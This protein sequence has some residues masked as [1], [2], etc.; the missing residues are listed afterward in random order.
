VPPRFRL[1]CEIG[2]PIADISTAIETVRPDGARQLFAM[3]DQGDYLE[4]IEERSQQAG[5]GQTAEK[6]IRR[7]RQGRARNDT[8][9]QALTFDCTFVDPKHGRA[10]S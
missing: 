5:I 8:P 1:R 7:L 9:L 10:G 2:L 6:A 3:R 4:S